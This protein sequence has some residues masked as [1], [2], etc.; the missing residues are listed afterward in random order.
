MDFASIH[1]YPE[2]GKVDKAIKVVEGYRLRKPIVVEE[3][4]PLSCSQDEVDEFID[5]TKNIAAGWISHYWRKPNP[6]AKIDAAMKNWLKYFQKKTPQ[7][8]G[9]EPI[10][11]SK[12]GRHFVGSRTGFKVYCMGFQLRPRY[13]GRLIEDYWTGEWPAVV[14]DFNAMKDLGQNTVRIHLQVAKF[15]ATPNEP[16]HV[17]LEQLARLVALAEKT[18]L[19]L[20]LTGLGCYHKQDVPK[21]YDSMSE[22]ARWDVQ[23]RFWQAVAKTCEKSPAVL[24]YDLMNEPV[25]PDKETEWLCKPL[26]KMY[27][28]Q[29]VC[30]NLN[31]RTKTQIAKAWEDK[32]VTC[33]RQVDKSHMVTVGAI[34]FNLK[35]PGAKDLF[36][37]RESGGN[38]DYVSVHFYPKSGQIEEAI[39]ALGEYDTGKPIVVEEMFPLNCDMEDIKTFVESSR[40]ICDGWI[41]F[42]WGKAPSKRHHSSFHDILMKE[43][44]DY[45]SQN[46]NSCALN[47]RKSPGASG[48]DM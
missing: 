2:T 47:D 15:M 27:F 46:S 26:G 43:W 29:R 5:G 22:S 28:T 7:I 36:Y 39:K 1:V 31:G 19:Y 9:L 41:G 11:L 6:N 35:W 16:N 21:W 48:G 20:D 42:Y 23:S 37:S 18:G 44:L 8:L 12:D 24:C 30:L 17:S 4:F 45:F 38:L 40:P 13:N 10:G 34:P 33:I 14:Q 32:L 3:L 25:M